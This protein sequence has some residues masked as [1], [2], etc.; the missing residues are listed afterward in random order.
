MEYQ[1]ISSLLDKVEEN[2]DIKKEE[3]LKIAA[4]V[5]EEELNHSDNVRHLINEVILLADT[6]ISEQNIDALVNAV[7]SQYDS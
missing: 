6:S 1:K 2:L 3:I 7:T 5:N 4:S